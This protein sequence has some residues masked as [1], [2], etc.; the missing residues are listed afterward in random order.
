MG[1][2][3]CGGGDLELFPRVRQM[4]PPGESNSS[5]TGG[6]LSQARRAKIQGSSKT[7]EEKEQECLDR[8]GS[9]ASLQICLGANNILL[10]IP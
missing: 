8:R 2:E 4:H 10:D 1:P 9:D 3:E 5:E 6:G 7:R